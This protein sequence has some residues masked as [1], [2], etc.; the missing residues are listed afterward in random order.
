ME[1]RFFHLEKVL[2][3]NLQ[4]SLLTQIL[5]MLMLKMMI[6]V[7]GN[8]VN[9]HQTFYGIVQAVILGVHFHRIL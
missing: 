6:K 3:E 8:Q 5:K 2:R 4:F 1:L 7:I 9:M